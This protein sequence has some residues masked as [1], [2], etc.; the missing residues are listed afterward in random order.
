MVWAPGAGVAL[1]MYN[2]DESIAGFARN[3]NGRRD[4]ARFGSGVVRADS[5]QVVAGYTNPLPGGGQIADAIY[6]PRTDRLYLTNIERNWLE[7]FNLADSTFRAPVSV[8][9]RPWGLAAWPRDRANLQTAIQKLTSEAEMGELFKVLAVGRD[10]DG[11]LIG[12]SSG[13]RRHRL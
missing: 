4:V 11:G 2:T 5:V 12:F 13:D 3:A 6:V 8:G 1:A 7:V 9:S 10:I